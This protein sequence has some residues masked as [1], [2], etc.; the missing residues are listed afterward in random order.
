RRD[1]DDRDGGRRCFEMLH[2]GDAAREDQVWLRA[3]RSARQFR[4]MLTSPLTG[5]SL[6]DQVASLDITVP[7]KF[8]EKCPI[9][10]K[11]AGFGDFGCRDGSGN[12]GN[13]MDLRGLLGPCRSQAGRDQQT[14]N[15]LPPLHSISFFG[16]GWLPPVLALD[17]NEQLPGRLRDVVPVPGR[18]CDQDHL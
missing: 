1:A 14:G 11:A 13:T 17:T 8:L 3:N 5:V 12:D 9:K 16:T 15:E 6:H 4:V 10:S 18:G 2:Q 7:T